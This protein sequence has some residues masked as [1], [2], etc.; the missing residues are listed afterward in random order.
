MALVHA[1]M[2]QPSLTDPETGRGRIHKIVLVVPVNTLAN[3]ENEFD[4][5]TKGMQKKLTIFNV[6]G[7]ETFA[8]HRL[9]KQWSNWGGILLTSDALFRNMAKLED[10]EKLLSATDA[11]VL[12]E[13]YV[14]LS[15]VSFIK[16]RY[17]IFLL[18]VLQ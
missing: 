9:V 7:A 3:W 2:L 1:M 13:R 6:S 15:F 16:R 11:I 10:I 5:W 18:F 14:I 8:R 12:D 4:K 17:P